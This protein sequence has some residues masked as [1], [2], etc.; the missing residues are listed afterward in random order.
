MSSIFPIGVRR[1]LSSSYGRPL[2]YLLIY[3]DGEDKGARQVGTVIPGGSMFKVVEF[4]PGVSPRIYRTNSINH[5]IVLSGEIDM[6]LGK[7]A[8]V[9]LSECDA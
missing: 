1:E 5:V 9:H 2:I 8:I 7:G 3:E 4:G 6:Q